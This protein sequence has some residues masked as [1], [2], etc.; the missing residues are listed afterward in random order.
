MERPERC[1]NSIYL[2]DFIQFHT[3]PK[4]LETEYLI[5]LYVKKGLT[6]S[7]IAEQIGASKQMVLGRLRKAGVQNTGGRGRAPEN[8]THHNPPYG[9]KVAHGRL[10]PNPKELRVVRLIVELID[11]KKLGWNAATREL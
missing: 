1:S 4:H 3:S 7:Q 6:G 10:A 8:Y 5:D 2:T 11:R 9:Y